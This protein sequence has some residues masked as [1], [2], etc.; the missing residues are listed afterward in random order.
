MDSFLAISLFLIASL[1]P[2]SL[3]N[4]S[5]NYV[6]FL[7]SFLKKGFCGLFTLSSFMLKMWIAPF[8]GLIFFWSHYLSSKFCRCCL[9][10]FLKWVWLSR[11]LRPAWFSFAFKVIYFSSCVLKEF[12]LFFLKSRIFSRI[13]FHVTITVWNFH[14][15][16]MYFFC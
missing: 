13:Y 12:I 3:F 9:I 1:L 16:A 7:F 8:L 11:S 2:N 5:R 15:T 14:A 10:A 4:S 6:D